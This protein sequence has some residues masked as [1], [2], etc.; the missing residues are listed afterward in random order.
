LPKVFPFDFL[1]YPD[2]TIGAITFP[3]SG[4]LVMRDLLFKWFFKVEKEKIILLYANY[5]PDGEF[6]FPLNP[7]GMAYSN[8]ERKSGGL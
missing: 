1:F 4:S 5:T 3:A 6:Y 8:P 7:G 2:L